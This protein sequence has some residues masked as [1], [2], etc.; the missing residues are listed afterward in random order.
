V[1]RFSS[2]YEEKIMRRISILVF[3]LAWRSACWP[4]HFLRA[5]APAVEQLA[6]QE[7]LPAQARLE[8]RLA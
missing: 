8:I 5:A 6:L 3:S 2:D 7:A 4:A 1:R